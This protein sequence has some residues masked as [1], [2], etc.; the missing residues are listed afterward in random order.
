MR[1]TH[2][3]QLPYAC[4]PRARLLHRVFIARALHLH[5]SY[6]TFAIQVPTTVITLAC[7]C[8]AC[9]LPAPINAVPP[10]DHCP[11]TALQF[12]LSVHDQCPAVAL[13]VPYRCTMIARPLPDCCPTVARCCLIRSVTLP[14]PAAGGGGRGDCES[15][16]CGRKRAGAILGSGG[17]GSR[18]G[19][20]PVG[21]ISGRHIGLRAT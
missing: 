15:G 17:G 13:P 5:G 8:R 4:V 3:R 20:G 7:Q 12:M 14:W 16:C 9:A 18:P 21:A 11:T 19:N 10:P 2:A 6:P 1:P